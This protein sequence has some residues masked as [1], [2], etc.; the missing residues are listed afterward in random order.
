[1]AKQKAGKAW[2]YGLFV[3]LFVCGGMLSASCFVFTF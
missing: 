1:M 2:A 3:C